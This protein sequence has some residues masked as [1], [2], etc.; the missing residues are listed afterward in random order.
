MGEEYT[1][2]EWY[3]RNKTVVFELMQ[4]DFEEDELTEEQAE[5]LSEMKRRKFLQENK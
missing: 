3:K 5:L 4:K 1:D 2:Y